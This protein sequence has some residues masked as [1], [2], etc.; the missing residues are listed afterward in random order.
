MKAGI[1]AGLLS[2]RLCIDAEIRLWVMALLAFDLCLWD[3]NPDDERSAIWCHRLQD[4]WVR[5]NTRDSLRFICGAG[6]SS[7][8]EF[9]IPLNFGSKLSGGSNQQ[10]LFSIGFYRGF[11]AVD[12][13]TL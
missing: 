13:N 10:F 6:T 8:A 12:A 7:A 11:H 2:F 1:P 9:F 3:L 5:L 4:C